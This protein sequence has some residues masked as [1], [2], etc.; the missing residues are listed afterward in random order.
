M[1]VTT[2]AILFLLKL[3]FAKKETLFEHIRKHYGGNV[4]TRYYSYFNS[5]K[6]EKKNKLDTDYYFMIYN[7]R[8]VNLFQIFLVLT[9]V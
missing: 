2:L 6:K 7:T 3:K 8:D 1:F 5:L 9:V 4:L